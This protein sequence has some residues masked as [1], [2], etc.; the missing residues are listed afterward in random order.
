[1]EKAMRLTEYGFIYGPARITRLWS[2]ARLGVFILVEGINKKGQMK[3]IAEVRVTP[4][5]RIKVTVELSGK[6]KKKGGSRA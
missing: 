6:K 5:G 3:D 4:G 1:M 2:D